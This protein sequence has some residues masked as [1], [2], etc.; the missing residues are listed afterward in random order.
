M[1][2]LEPPAATPE[3]D[4]D[5]VVCGWCGAT[6]VERLSVYGPLHL[7]ESWY[8]RVCHSAFERV[9]NRSAQAGDAERR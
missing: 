5:P 8:C 4:L 1:A 2:A 6:D 3:P 7:G 9:R